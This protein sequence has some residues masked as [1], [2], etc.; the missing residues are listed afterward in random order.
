MGWGFLVLRHTELRGQHGQN[1]SPD[2]K[3][4]FAEFFTIWKDTK[5]EET[6]KSAHIRDRRWP[7][8]GE[9]FFR[10][11][12]MY[13]VSAGRLW[14]RRVSSPNGVLVLS[15]TIG[16]KQ[17]INWTTRRMQV[18]EWHMRCWW[19][20]EQA[21]S[22]RFQTRKRICIESRRTAGES[23][24]VR[25]RVLSRL[26]SIRVSASVG[27]CVCV[28]VF[29]CKFFWQSFSHA[30]EACHLSNLVV[31]PKPSGAD[32][33]V[34]SPV[35]LCIFFFRN[36]IPVFY[37]NFR[38]KSLQVVHLVPKQSESNRSW[39]W[40]QEP[41]TCKDSHCYSCCCPG[42]AHFLSEPSG[43]LDPRVLAKSLASMLHAIHPGGVK[44]LLTDW[45]QLCANNKNDQMKGHLSH[46][47]LVRSLEDSDE[48]CLVSRVHFLRLWHNC[49]QG[50][51]RKTQRGIQGARDSLVEK[52]GKEAEQS[53]SHGTGVCQWGG[54][55]SHE[56]RQLSIW[57]E[58][59]GFKRQINWVWVQQISGYFSN[60]LVRFQ[61]NLVCCYF[62]C[63][64]WQHGAVML[65]Q[66]RAGK[67][68]KW[69]MN[70]G[71]KH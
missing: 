58:T 63:S 56:S 7:I 45:R 1:F 41:C 8:P 47:N 14:S 60:S 6:T 51:W 54:I 30:H 13:I 34:H 46:E 70:Y 42:F 4:I 59:K 29:F 26:C 28:C 66:A 10:F 11:F 44:L 65:E 21:R 53:K 37:R 36:T 57:T 43:S 61:K 20:C 64:S 67:N 55:T 5:L 17:A 16:D 23:T 27:L 68:R 38:A 40:R 25:R 48:L 33:S 15:W 32:L 62:V 50:A 3:S 71:K 52:I 9:I 19:S 12:G 35:L 49:P 2:Q 18:S 69:P 22:C 39:H 24:R 31:F